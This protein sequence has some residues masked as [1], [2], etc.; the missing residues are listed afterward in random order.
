MRAFSIALLSLITATF[1]NAATPDFPFTIVKNESGRIERIELSQQAALAEDGTNLLDL[2]KAQ[3]SNGEISQSFTSDEQ[4]LTKEEQKVFNRAKASLLSS[5]AVAEVNNSRLQTEFTAALPKL[6]DIK[7]YRLLASPH[8]PTAFDK[9]NAAK[10][11]VEQVL[12]TARKALQGP[13]FEIFEFLVSETLEGLESRREFHQY[14]LLHWIAQ[15][16]SMFTEEERNFIR[17]SVFYSRLGVMDFFARRKAKAAWATYGTS[18]YNALIKKCNAGPCFPVDS[19]EV[20]NVL[21]K[22]SNWSKSTSVAHDFAKPYKV[23]NTRVTVLLLKLALKFVPGPGFAKNGVKKWLDSQYVVQRRTEGL[24]YETAR[25]DHQ[26]D[27]AAWVLVGSAN[28]LIAGQ[29][30]R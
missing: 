1:A 18:E 22:K 13:A 21:V 19:N 25:F 23:R 15:E 4:A 2:L 9:E 16:P 5:L 14:R 8:D 24:L 20:R 6:K 29:H 10:E 7:V 27:L 3:L 11:I 12:A 28:P 26:N 17:S 30:L